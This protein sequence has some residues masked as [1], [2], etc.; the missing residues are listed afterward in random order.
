MTHPR[1]REL[2]R[3]S[4]LSGQI[5]T[6]NHSQMSL[7]KL[8]KL[9]TTGKFVIFCLFLDS[10]AD[11]SHGD[12]WISLMGT[13]RIALFSVSLWAHEWHGRSESAHWTLMLNVER[14]RADAWGTSSHIER[15]RFH[16]VFTWVGDKVCSRCPVMLFVTVKKWGQIWGAQMN[17]S[18]R[19]AEQVDFYSLGLAWSVW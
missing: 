4:V 12:A 3:P 11:G 8:I 10:A 18:T 14:L 17:P 5:F 1:E 13:N 16:S 7:A 2:A 9:P 19:E 15:G 6:E